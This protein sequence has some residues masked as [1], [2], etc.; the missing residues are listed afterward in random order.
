MIA[1]IIKLAGYLRNM[2][3]CYLYNSHTLIRKLILSAIVLWAANGFSQGYHFTYYTLNEGIP[4][5]LVKSV[6]VSHDGFLYLA[7]DE[8][9]VFFNG[10]DFTTYRSQ[11]HSQ[12]VK[13]VHS[14]PNGDLMVSDDLGVSLVQ[15]ADRVPVFQTIQKGQVL[16]TDST[17]WYPKMIYTDS[18]GETWVAD[19][20][21]IYLHNEGKLKPVHISLAELPENVQRSFIFCDDRMGN[22]FA[23]HE[24]GKVFLIDR[25]RMIA[26]EVTKQFPMRHYYHCALS[27]PG[28]LLLSGEKGL[29]FVKTGESGKVIQQSPLIQGIEFSWLEHRED[30]VWIGATW[31]DGLFEIQLNNGFV[32]RWKRI[33][34]FLYNNGNQIA[35]DHE[36]NLWIASDNGLVLMQKQMFEQILPETIQG[37]IQDILQADEQ[38]MIISNGEKVFEVKESQE[39]R[40]VRILYSNPQESILKLAMT[41]DGIYM[42]G[43]RGNVYYRNNAGVVRKIMTGLET[44]I[45]ILAPD[46]NHRIWFCQDGRLVPGMIENAKQIVSPLENHKIQSRIISI[47]LHPA[48]GALFLGGSSDDAYLYRY[49]PERDQLVNLSQ[50]LD[51][52]HNVPL[53]INDMAFHGDS[54]WLATTFGVMLVHKNS[55]RRIPL[56]G[57]SETTIKGIVSDTEGTLWFSASLGIVKYEKGEYYIF[58]E[59]DGVPSKT[60]SYRSLLLDHRNRLWAG[61]ISGVAYTR[62]THP[63]HAMPPPKACNLAVNGSPESG[64]DGKQIRLRAG[65]FLKINL[66]TPSYPSKSLLFRYRVLHNSDS[67]EWT[68]C[69]SLLELYTNNWP[70]GKYRIQIIARKSGN[71]HWSPP[72]DIDMELRLPWFKN[73]F[74]LSSILVLLVLGTFLLIR[75][76]SRKHKQKQEELED[77]IHVR[78]AEIQKQKSFIE[79]RNEEIRQ[80]NA[81]LEH[82]LQELTTA[83]LKAEHLANARSL[84]LS[85]VSHELRTPLNAVIGMTYILLSDNPRFDQIENLNTLKF[86]AENLLALIND[87]LDYSKIDAGKLVF[88]EADFDLK[89]RINSIVQVLKV[90]ADEKGIRVESFVD[91][92]LPD[93]LTGDPTRLNQILFNIAGNAVKFTH[94][95]EVKLNVTLVRKWEKEVEIRF[96]V[97][98]TGIGISPDHLETI[99]ESFSQAGLDITRKYGG[100][101]LGLAITQKLVEMQN[102]RIEVLSHQGKG[103]TFTIFLTYRISEKTRESESAIVLKDFTMFSGQEVLVV[104]D[105]QVNLIVARKFLNNWNLKA[106]TAENGIMAYEKAMNKQYFLILMDLQMPEMDGR[107]ATEAIRRYEETHGLQPVPIFALTAS[108]MVENQQQLYEAGMNDFITKPFNPS[109]LNYKIAKLLR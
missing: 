67:T 7:T 1:G 57:L 76:N 40:T 75:L 90:K 38:T 109:E 47:R 41:P 25:A 69:K 91:P 103:S 55:A 28:E 106:D 14:L 39:G 30:N 48:S 2:T 98:D 100:T 82:T 77:I 50:P 65:S 101:G 84:F 58:A 45:F 33:D 87:I 52:E 13:F 71:F 9:L 44:P 73:P 72:L 70:A 80:K 64:F 63:A 15:L 54:V 56:G 10:Q 34:E 23:F 46:R 94:Q 104:D 49:D 93:F 42:A 36:G 19:N 16:R 20:R 92:A 31:S 26:D 99:F 18:N 83:K 22:L 5:E 108:A 12:Y 37:Y 60:S 105:N 81:E 8:G 6:T 51:F 88:E 85:T 97:S 17:L 27:K 89:D 78:T 59:R 68:V 74:V 11:L 107:E 32:S 24:G 3:V 102:G 66:V 95:G 86:S 4:T 79:A 29:W 35:K 53:S 96:E 43:S 62:N 61:T 21:T